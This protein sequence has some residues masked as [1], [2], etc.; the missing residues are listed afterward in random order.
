MKS[1]PEPRPVLR[2]K[3]S[4]EKVRNNTQLEPVAALLCRLILRKNV[5]REE[6][7]EKD[8]EKPGG[9]QR[10]ERFQTNHERIR[11]I[12]QIFERVTMREFIV[13]CFTLNFDEET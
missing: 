6:Q 3:R 2:N 13:C 8:G 7:A 4:R 9:G 12:N 1:L 11:T 10:A 5:I